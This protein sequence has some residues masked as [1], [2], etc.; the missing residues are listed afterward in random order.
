[1]FTF[2][3]DKEDYALKPMNCPGHILMYNSQLR[4]YRELPLRFADFGALHRNE[5]AGTLGGLTRVRKLCQDDAHIFCTPEQIKDEIGNLLNFIDCIYSDIFNFE[6]HL[7]L[8]TRPENYMGSVEVWDKAEHDLQEALKATGREFKINPGDGAFYGPKIDLHVKDALGRS[9]QCATVQLDFQ[10]PLRFNATYEGKDGA[11]HHA[12]M[13][14][15]AIY[16][17]IERFMGILTEHYAG[18]FPLW[19][20]PVQ[21]IVMSVADRHHEAVEKAREMMMNAGLRVEADLRSESIPKKVRDAQLKQIN[22]ICV[23]GDKENDNNSVTVRTRDNV[24]QGEK[25]IESFIKELV[26]EIENKK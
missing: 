24:V 19:L 25:P 9:W 23:I 11:R 8:S 14:H 3:V 10:L 17:S 13:I 20:S 22:Y 5:L 2:K 6:Y 26:S 16:G 12:I 18:K 1:M 7:E 21:A 15:R 4:S